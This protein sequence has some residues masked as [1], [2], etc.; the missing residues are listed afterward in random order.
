[1]KDAPPPPVA[2]FLDF[3]LTRKQVPAFEDG[4]HQYTTEPPPSL[5]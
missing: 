4:R 2:L 5:A 3:A 1:M